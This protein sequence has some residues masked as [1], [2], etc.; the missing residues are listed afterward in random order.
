MS[1]ISMICGI[2]EEYK[3]HYN[4]FNLLTL[5]F[6]QMCRYLGIYINSI[7]HTLAKGSYEVT[8]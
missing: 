8:R 7:M 2:I 6:I 4:K 1:H 5:W 3:K